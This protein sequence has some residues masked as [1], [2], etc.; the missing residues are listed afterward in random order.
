LLENAFALMMG[1]GF[2]SNKDWIRQGQDILKKE[3]E[4]QILSDGAHFELSPMYHQIIFFRLL[5]LIDWYSDVSVKDGDFEGYLKS[6]AVLMLSWLKNIS[7]KNGDI[8]HF[9]DS[10][11]GIAYSTN[12]L[13][14]YA[15][16]L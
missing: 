5:E 11:E 8:P 1:G 16:R 10:A 3:L 15:D 14:D 2:F 9:N 7:F 12:W 13:I 4:E 6:K